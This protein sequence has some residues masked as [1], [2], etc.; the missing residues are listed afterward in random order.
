MTNMVLLEITQESMIIMEHMI[1]KENMVITEDMM[2]STTKM[3]IPFN[4]LEIT[5]RLFFK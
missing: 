5:N 1:I 3:V 4:L 2:I